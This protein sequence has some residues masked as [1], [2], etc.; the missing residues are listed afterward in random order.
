[1]KRLLCLFLLLCLVPVSCMADPGVTLCYRMN[2]YASAYNEDHPGYFSYDTMMIDV[3][4]M[5]DFKTAYYMK[6][7]W[8]DGDV[9]TTGY[10]KCTFEKG[11]DSKYV[12]SFPNGEVMHFYYDDESRFWLEMDGGAF[13]LLR[14][15]QFDLKNDLK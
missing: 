1:M 11:P 12:L 15:E 7:T 10:V 13:H 14:C 9:D 2:H 5:D 6:T 8:A 4:I 3:F